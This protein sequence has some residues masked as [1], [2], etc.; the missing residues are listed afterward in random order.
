LDDAQVLIV[1]ARG[2]IRVIRLNR[3]DALNAAS[4]E[5]HTRLAGVW[6]EVAG[7]PECAVA[8]LTGNGR[9]FSAGGDMEVLA[10]MNHDAEFR[11]ATLAEAR[12]IVHQLV[13]FPVPLIA[14]VNGPAVGLGCSL[15][16]LADIVIMDESA[17]LSDPH[18]SV[19][20]VAADGGALTWP[21]LT[22][23]LRA[24]EYLFTGD[25]VP[26]RAA[27]ELGLANRVVADGT[28]LEA[29]LELAERLAAQPR[30]AL[31]DTKRALNRQLERSVFDVLDF[32]LAAETISI[33][34][35]EHRQLVERFRARARR[36]S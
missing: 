8:V 6:A 35:D 7:D 21:L 1:E 25:R 31:R 12:Q 9:A 23:L 29:A 33:V 14:A 2:P 5:L 24:K 22:S 34:S 4:P 16:G 17:Y 19:G 27:V 13:A 10:R 28:C 18:V 20:L 30:Q 36:V 32:A 3:P 11:A 15:V 26:A